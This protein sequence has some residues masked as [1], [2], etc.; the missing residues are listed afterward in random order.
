[1]KN[2]FRK[3]LMIIEINVFYAVFDSLTFFF[4][5]NNHFNNY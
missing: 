3:F 5:D 2:Y 1:M 4:R